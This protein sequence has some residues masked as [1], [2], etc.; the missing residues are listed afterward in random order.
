MRILS[1]TAVI[2]MLAVTGAF[3]RQPR[4]Q[5]NEVMRTEYF[6]VHYDPSD[7]Y[8]ARI[9]ADTAARE[10]VRIADDLGYVVESDRPFPLYAYPT[11][12][13]FTNSGGLKLHKYTVGTART[14]DE[15][16]S[17]DASGALASTQEV[18][19]HEITHALMFRLLG[20]RSGALPL[21]LYEGIAKYQS[22]EPARNDD[23]LIADAARNGTLMPLSDLKSDFPEDRVALSYAE[24]ASAVR[25]MV[26]HHG[27]SSMRKLIEEAGKAG[28]FDKAMKAA[29]GL[30]PTEFENKWYESATRRYRG[31]R[32]SGIIAGSVSAFMATLAIAAFLVRRRRKRQAALEWEQ[33]EFEEALRAQM[34]NDWWR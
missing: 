13:A 32:I 2:I 22:E 21:W 18:L 9:A 4:D 29:I 27:K 8:L 33:E 31:V 23:L 20:R 7:P 16:I 6:V 15:R 24:S 28:R 1:L 14:G 17:V 19:A 26:E 34:G 30:D 25:Y 10:L 12:Y 5:L 11:H 3:A